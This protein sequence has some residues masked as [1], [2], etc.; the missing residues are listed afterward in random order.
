MEHPDYPML[1][2]KKN[3]LSYGEVQKLSDEFAA[4]LVELGVKKGDRVALI[5]PNCPQCMIGRF[6][7]WK[8]GAVLAH[9][10]PVYTEPELEHALKDCGASTA[11]VMTPFYNQ[12]KKVQPRTAVKTVIATSIKEYL[13]AEIKPLFEQFVEKQQGHFIELQAGD[14]W[15]QDLLA[16]HAGAK[17]PNV[18]V[19]PSDYA[20][21]LF[22]GGT[23]G[24]P[25]GVVG[26]H[27]CQVITGLQFQY[28][29]RR[30]YQIL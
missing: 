9:L 5:M 21:I 4:A 15:L 17:R 11:V 23:T 22:S 24:T 25:K 18:K 13:P 8:V 1:L 26:D 12:L 30:R 19:M 7:A 3:K 10:N 14:F 6:G 29:V 16:K 27:H 20:L 28:V 2:F